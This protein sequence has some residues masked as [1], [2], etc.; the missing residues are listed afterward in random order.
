LAALESPDEPPPALA[1]RPPAWRRVAVTAFTLLAIGLAIVVVATGPPE[2]LAYDIRL[3]LLVLAGGALVNAGQWR[4]SVCVTADEVV[5]RNLVRTRRIPLPAV[6]AVETDDRR[7]T[8]RLR[9]GRKAVLRA[10]TSPA[11]AGRIANAIVTAAGP[12][13]CLAAG[14][15]SAPVLIATPWVTMLSAVSVAFLAAEGYVV[16]PALVIATLIAAALVGCVALGS[17]LL[18][19]GEQ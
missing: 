4:R 5:M 13:A 16:D 1:W 12:A 19:P 9:S 18:W 7:V 17:T 15:P 2:P 3:P 8:V 6:A 14:R 11:A 10:A